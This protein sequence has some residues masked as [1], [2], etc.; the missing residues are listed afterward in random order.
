MKL[1]V[2]QVEVIIIVSQHCK[3]DTAAHTKKLRQDTMKRTPLSRLCT[4][5]SF[6]LS[7]PPLTDSVVVV[8]GWRL[9]EYGISSS[10][11]T[12]SSS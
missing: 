12:S 8:T 11:S 2:K 4:L 7:S 10:Y 9:G 3:H 1:Q 5:A 6:S